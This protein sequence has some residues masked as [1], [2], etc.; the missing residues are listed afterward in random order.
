MGRTA[1]TYAAV[2]SRR[3]PASPAHLVLITVEDL[4]LERQTQNVPGTTDARPNWQRPWARTIDDVLADPA[5]DAALAA[6][7]AARPRG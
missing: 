3:R 5:V 6:V 1:S 4:W 7:D 2:S